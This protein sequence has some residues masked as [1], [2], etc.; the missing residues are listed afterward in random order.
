[1]RAVCAK[2]ALYVQH[3]EGSCLKHPYKGALAR[4][5]ELH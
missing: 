1:M 2:E 5:F 4:R 3:S